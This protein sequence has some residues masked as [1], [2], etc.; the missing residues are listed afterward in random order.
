MTDEF[1]FTKAPTEIIERFVSITPAEEVSEGVRVGDTVIAYDKS[2]LELSITTEEH[3][4][5]AEC[6]ETVYLIDLRLKNPTSVV[7][8]SF[9]FL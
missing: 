1:K 6:S 5:S 4:A 8:V 3:I 7:A 2:V 9:K